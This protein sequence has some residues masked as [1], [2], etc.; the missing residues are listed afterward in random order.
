MTTPPTSPTPEPL[1][2]PVCFNCGKPATC[3]GAYEGAETE[4]YACDE[5]CGH[6]N[7]DGHCHPITRHQPAPA[8][9]EKEL[10]AFKRQLKHEGIKTPA[11]VEGGETPLTDAALIMA[12]KV[13]PPVSM[14]LM[15]YGEIVRASFARTLEHRA[16]AAEARAHQLNVLYD[17]RLKHSLEM[18]SELTSLRA[19]LATLK[20]SQQLLLDERARD[21]GWVTEGGEG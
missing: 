18:H 19:E 17:E 10:A 7:E 1:L 4:N 6:G 16:I 20:E 2:L 9:A 11:P 14:H 12:Y 8:S 13:N 3:L 21:K 15:G 5:C